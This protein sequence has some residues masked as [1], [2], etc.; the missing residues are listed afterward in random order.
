MKIDTKKL[1]DEPLSHGAN[2]PVRKKVIVKNGVVP[3]ITQVAI[4]TFTKKVS[5]KPHAHNHPTMWELYYVLEGEA[6]YKI[7]LTSYRVKPGD[8]LV[9][10][11]QT[12][13]YQKITKAPHKILYWGVAVG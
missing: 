9:I 6:I 7:G 3:G 2:L 13:H 5:M 12:H 10:P 4:S 11:P 8:F 1:K